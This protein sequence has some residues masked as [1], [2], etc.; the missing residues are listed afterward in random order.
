MLWQ[1]SCDLG[2]GFAFNA[3]S[4]ALL[5]RMLAQQCDLQP[6]EL[7]WSAGDAHVYLNHEHLVQEQLA[8]TPRGH[9][10]LKINR[11]PESIFSYRIEDF[12]VLDYEPH[13]HIAAPVAV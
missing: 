13:A 7:V 2:L 8:R 12:E 9:P 6:G 5:L 4:A 1:R 11:R 3:F 10:L